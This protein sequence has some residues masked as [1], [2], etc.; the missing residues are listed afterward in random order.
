MTDIKLFEKFIKKSLK[1]L[2]MFKK[3][4][5]FVVVVDGYCAFKIPYK[6]KEY[7]KVLKQCTFQTLENDFSIRGK[8]LTIVEVPDLMH[9]FNKE[10]KQIEDT[11]LTYDGGI[12]QLRI[13]ELDDTHIY[14]NQEKLQYINLG[15][16][17][18]LGVGSLE[19]VLFKKDD[20]E[21]A[22]LPVRYEGY[23]FKILKEE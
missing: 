14:L 3:Y 16:Y 4:K 23:K 18:C 17:K 10:Y 6:S 9:I 21:C 15:N 2:L 1:G 20:I 7:L 5:D 22:V 19:P 8:E 13:F 12:H 11:K